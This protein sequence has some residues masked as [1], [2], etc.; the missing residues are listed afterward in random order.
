[1]SQLTIIP[2]EL[3]QLD[4]MMQVINDAYAQ[5]E[6]S[7]FKKGSRINTKKQAL[8]I[9]DSMFAAYKEE[10]VMIGCMGIEHKG[11]YAFIGPFAVDSQYKGRG[12]GSQMLK[13]A[14]NYILN[15]LNLKIAEI[16]VRMISPHLLKWYKDKGY[17]EFKV[18][19]VTDVIPEKQ[20]TRTDVNFIVFRKYLQ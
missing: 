15:H 13:W 6:M 18:I 16:S 10:K 7:Q 3:N 9:M 8:D 2:I 11:D 4:K 19:P 17:E 1:M 5:T 14:E 20:L 12:F